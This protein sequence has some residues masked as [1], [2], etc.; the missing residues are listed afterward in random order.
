MIEQ[1]YLFIDGGHLRRYYSESVCDWFIGEGE[2]NFNILKN[3][4]RAL[5]CFYYDC[6]DDIKRDSESE[7]DFHA[8]VAEQELYFNKIREV[9]GTHV[10][11]GSLTGSAKNKRQKKVDILLAVDMMNHATRHNMNRAVLLSGD[12][13]FE[14]VVA[15]LIEMGV[16]TEV[17]GDERHTSRDLASAADSY[18][19]IGFNDYFAWSSEDLKSKY[20]RP[21]QWIGVSMFN[22]IQGGNLINEGKIGEFQVRLYDSPNKFSAFFVHPESSQSFAYTLKDLERLK[23]YLK[24]MHGEVK[25]Q[26]SA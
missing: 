10:R 2:I 14:P 15:S 22:V 6:L 20:P 8:R 21:D 19:K 24:V 18:R 16:I 25:W 12:R 13:D 4:F 1:T 11:L 9:Y 23:L 3:A 17:A 26:Q 7:A 5:K